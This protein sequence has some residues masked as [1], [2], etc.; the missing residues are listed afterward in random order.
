MGSDNKT[1]CTNQKPN[2]ENDEASVYL[3]ASRPC[4]SWVLHCLRPASPL[5]SRREEGVEKKPSQITF[6]RL[7]WPQLIPAAISNS[8]AK[9][10]VGSVACL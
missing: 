7:S 5:P 9:M 6:E 2:V 1:V 8:P 4:A 3:V 10:L